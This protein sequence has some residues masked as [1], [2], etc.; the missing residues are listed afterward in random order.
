[1][2]I[3]QFA[4]AP[5]K[6]YKFP[7]KSLHNLSSCVYIETLIIK[8]PYAEFFFRTLQ[9]K[10][11]QLT[12]SCFFIRLRSQLLLQVNDLNHLMGQILTLIQL[13]RS[14]LYRPEKS[15]CASFILFKVSMHL[16]QI[17]R[18]WIKVAFKFKMVSNLRF[19]LLLMLDLN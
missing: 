13:L 4:T 12:D 19:L 11:R 15:R 17:L 18:R 6:D 3:I 2:K 9:A 14:Q 1:M 7:P 16:F 10:C 8:S 5:V